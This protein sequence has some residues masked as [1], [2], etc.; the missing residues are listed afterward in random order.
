MELETIYRTVFKTKKNEDFERLEFL[1]RV[2]SGKYP[3]GD[4]LVDLEDAIEMEGMEYT[5]CKGF[6]YKTERHINEMEAIRTT[7]EWYKRFSSTIQEGKEEIGKALIEAE[8]SPVSDT[9]EDCLKVLKHYREKIEC[10][11]ILRAA[12]QTPKKHRTSAV[13]ATAE[14]LLDTI[15]NPDS[16]RT[17]FEFM[18][19]YEKKLIKNFN[20]AVKKGKIIQIADAY[21]EL[22][23]THEPEVMEYA[24]NSLR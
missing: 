8:I 23:L 5:I 1:E 17:I 6:D 22:S 14:T 2:I 4:Q 20:R 12:S 24:K 13:Y 15:R 10:I 3:Y 9:L 19:K 16:R 18:E 7:R 11:R 21:M